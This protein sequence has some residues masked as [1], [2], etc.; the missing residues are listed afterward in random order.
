MVDQTSNFK[1]PDALLAPY[2]QMNNEQPVDGSSSSPTFYRDVSGP[3]R[4]N[5]LFDSPSSGNNRYE[6]FGGGDVS[7]G[8]SQETS[9][10]FNTNT[11]TTNNNNN[12]SNSFTG[13]NNSLA[14]NNA[15]SSNFN[16]SFSTS[17][18]AA[19]RKTASKKADDDDWDDWN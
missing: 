4:D 16:S 7:A 11:A 17:T 9:S 6:G 18:S 8:R 12:Y 3:N 10:G 5:N 2:S 14:N 19:A 1:G 13:N 15:T